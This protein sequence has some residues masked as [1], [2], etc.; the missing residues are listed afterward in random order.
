[1]KAS[2]SGY[3]ILYSQDTTLGIDIIL[4]KIDLSGKEEWTETYI[5]T[6]S[7]FGYDIAVLPDD[8]YIIT[9]TTAMT[10]VTADVFIIKADSEGRRIWSKAYGGIHNEKG[11]S[12]CIAQDS[13]IIVTG[14]TTSFG[15]EFTDV[16]LFKI[17]MDGNP[18]F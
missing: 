8:N 6:E 10:S 9:G 11:I 4:T 5:G 15:A 7:M 1:M 12:L 17:D 14:K 16:Y 3:I 18:I 13:S 2:D